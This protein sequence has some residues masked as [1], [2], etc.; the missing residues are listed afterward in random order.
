MINIIVGNRILGNKE[1]N[2]YGKNIENIIQKNTNLSKESIIET[3]IKTVYPKDVDPYYHVYSLYTRG[4][5]KKD[6]RYLE[7]TIKMINYYSNNKD[8]NEEKIKRI[9]KVEYKTILA[10]EHFNVKNYERRKQNLKNELISAYKMS[11]EEI[12]AL[13]KEVENYFNQ[14]PVIYYRNLVFN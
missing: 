11:K 9:K 5:S 6:I 4:C 3:N 8:L 1:E 12:L 13:E 7:E 14:K 10:L 2:N